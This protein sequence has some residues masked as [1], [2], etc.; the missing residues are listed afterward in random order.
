MQRLYNH[1]LI[2][3][4]IVVALKVYVGLIPSQI[5]LLYLCLWECEVNTH[6]LGV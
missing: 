6:K 2:S 1:W 4:A 3:K 5:L